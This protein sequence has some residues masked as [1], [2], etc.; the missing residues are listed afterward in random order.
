MDI[1]YTPPDQPEGEPHAEPAPPCTVALVPDAQLAGATAQTPDADTGQVS[2]SHDTEPF[3]FDP[4]AVVDWGD[5]DPDAARA[6]LAASQTLAVVLQQSVR[7]AEAA[8]GPPFLGWF[9]DQAVPVTTGRLRFALDRDQLLAAA[10]SLVGLGCRPKNGE[11]TARITLRDGCFKAAV[12]SDR[13][14]FGEVAISPKGPIV[15]L[16]S[17][18]A[19]VAFTVPIRKLTDSIRASMPGN[20]LHLEFNPDARR[21]V[22]SG[23]RDGR[24]RVHTGVPDAF[25]MRKRPVGVPTPVCS[26]NPVPLAAGLRL[27]GTIIKPAAGKEPTFWGRAYVRDGMI[28]GSRKGVLGVVQAAGVAGLKAEVHARDLSPIGKLMNRL[29]PSRTGLFATDSHALITDGQTW[30]GLH[31]EEATPFPP[32]ALEYFLSQKPS[33]EVMPSCDQLLPALEGLLATVKGGL[34]AGWVRLRTRRV[35]GQIRLIVQAADQPKWHC[36][37]Y[38]IDCSVKSH[39]GTSTSATNVDVRVDLSA[40]RNLVAYARDVLEIANIPLDVVLPVA[41]YP[42]PI[43]RLRHVVEGQGGHVLSVFLMGIP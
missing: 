23:L 10:E 21:L 20:L 37:V 34:G 18:A 36:G 30:V 38:D 4:N 33:Y 43:L 32:G 9:D 39:D 8:G 14:D 7:E 24:R 26:L 35:Y 5:Q 1:E 41:G 29:D 16:A 12:T 22:F 42:R 13:M 3:G 11:A 25:D 17:D 40:L 28:F 6:A 15:G 31:S 27:L 2:A 19:P